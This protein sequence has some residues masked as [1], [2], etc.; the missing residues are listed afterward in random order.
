MEKLKYLFL[1]AIYLGFAWLGMWLTSKPPSSLSVIWLPAGIGL[2]AAIRFGRKGLI[3]VFLASSL[4]N[5]G[6]GY[7]FAKENKVL[8]LYSGLISAIVDILQTW[9]ALRLILVSRLLLESPKDLIIILLRICLIPPSLTVWILPLIWE[10]VAG[11]PIS[12]GWIGYLTK[13]AQI[14]SADMLGIFLVIP[15]FLSLRNYSSSRILKIFIHSLLLI[16]VPIMV[17]FLV[18]I[19]LISLLAPVIL[20]LVVKY[21]LAGSTI[22]LI[23]VCGFLLL[24]AIMYGNSN[25]DTNWFGYFNLSLFILCLGLVPHYI[26]LTL[27]Q[28]KVANETLEMR[29]SQRTKD[30]SIANEQLELAANTDIL[31]G[32][33]NRRAFLNRFKYESD[34]S[35]RTGKPYSIAILDLDHFKSINDR[36]GHHA[37]DEILLAFSQIMISHLRTTDIACRWG[38]EE[39]LILFPDTKENEAN[40]PLTR[41]RK[42]VETSEDLSSKASVNLTVSIGISD[43]VVSPTES[44]ISN[45]DKALYAAKATGRNRICF[46]DNLSEVI[47]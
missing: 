37:G 29:V 1:F 31:T 3:L 24:Y 38:G 41:I 8:A 36:F 28:L 11:V 22:S 25:P 4:A 32:L 16:L 46:F 40:I 20:Y 35:S 33:L 17:A 43:S 10:N 26:A 18:Y 2:V 9:I 39:F 45:A 6:Y 7:I 34:R 42:F 5:G 12:N 27:E 19:P 30:L 44:I 14:L 23:I 15:L 13:T 21:R 47:Y